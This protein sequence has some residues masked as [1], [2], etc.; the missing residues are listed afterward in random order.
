MFRQESQLDMFMFTYR[1]DRTR[2]L[3]HPWPHHHAYHNEPM[4][5]N[6][7]T[8]VFLCLEAGGRVLYSVNS[9]AENC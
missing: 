8:F 1:L 3:V 4:E 9:A 2:M 5:L 7:I 6:G